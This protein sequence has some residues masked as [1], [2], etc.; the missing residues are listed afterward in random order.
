[1][2][3]DFIIKCKSLATFSEGSF[4]Y[5]R[6]IDGEWTRQKYYASKM[7]EHIANHLV[8]YFKYEGVFSIEKEQI[9]E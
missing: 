8:E 6:G 5:W 2:K 9:N 4:I 1:M 3:K 7:P